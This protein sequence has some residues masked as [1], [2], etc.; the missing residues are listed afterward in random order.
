MVNA[1]KIIKER[2][3]S[4]FMQLLLESAK[5]LFDTIY[6]SRSRMDG[7]GIIYDAS[8]LLIKNINLA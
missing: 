2:S 5:I 8:V 3:A 6:A 1:H 4:F 7:H